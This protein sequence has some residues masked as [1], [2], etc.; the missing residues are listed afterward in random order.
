MK[1]QQ[2]TQQPAVVILQEDVRQFEKVAFRKHA[3]Y[4]VV[5]Q[6]GA[7]LMIRNRH[8][9]VAHVRADQVVFAG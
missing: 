1:A 5:K 3:P 8:G 9:L 4:Y 6:R 7:H 2:N